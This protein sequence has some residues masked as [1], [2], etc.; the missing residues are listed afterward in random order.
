MLMILC[1]SLGGKLFFSKMFFI[2]VSFSEWKIE[3]L[4]RKT[5][6]AKAKA[7]LVI[8]C[9][10]CADMKLIMRPDAIDL[11]YQLVMIVLFSRISVRS[12]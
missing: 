4:N 9:L 7:V 1:I 2:L 12:K 6:L 5:F 11:V 10:G 3:L 8:I